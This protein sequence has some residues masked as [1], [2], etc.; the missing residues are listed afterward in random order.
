MRFALPAA[1]ALAVAAGGFASA[2]P[3]PAPAPEA[4]APRACFY[5]NN[6]SNYAS[7]DDETVFVRVGVKDVYRLDLMGHCH[8][9]GSA[10]KLGLETRGSSFVCDALDVTVVAGSSIGPQRCPVTKVTKLTEAEVAA[11]PKKQ[12]P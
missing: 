10:L 3:E 9:V 8:D 7:D 6:V 4:K 2:A 12:R 5:V 11:L 1:L